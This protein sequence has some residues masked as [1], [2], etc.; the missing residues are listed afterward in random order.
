MSKTLTNTIEW[1]IIDKNEEGYLLDLPDDGE[2]VLLYDGRYFCIDELDS[3]GDEAWFD[4]SGEIEVGWAWAEIPKPPRETV[5][6]DRRQRTYFG[7][8]E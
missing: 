4:C 3:D 7:Q 5:A 6:R 8:E 1:H 2:A